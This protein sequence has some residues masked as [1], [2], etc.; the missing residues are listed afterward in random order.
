MALINIYKKFLKT[1]VNNNIKF[2]KNLLILIEIG[3]WMAHLF[4]RIN[5]LKNIVNPKRRIGNQ[6]KI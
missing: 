5:F 6:A 1:D 2:F 3:P 4:C